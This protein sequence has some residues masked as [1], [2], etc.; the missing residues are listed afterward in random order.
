[1]PK[2][3]IRWF[4]FFAM[5]VACTIQFF[6]DVEEKQDLL[7]VDGM[8]TDQN[9]TYRIRLSRTTP[10]G[11]T[12]TRRPVK[13][14]TVTIKDENGTIAT[15]KEFPVGT[16]YTDST[17]FRGHVGGRYALNIKL[18]N[19]YYETDYI[20]MKPVPP[21]DSL[22]YEKVVITASKDSNDI[23]EGCKIYLNSYDPENKCLY[24]RWDYLE[25]WE[26]RIPY[27]TENQICWI[28]E[29]SGHILIKNTSVFD[30]AKVTKYLVNFVTNKTDR[31]KVKYS[32]LV[33]QY[34]LDQAEYDFW[35][36]VEGIS[37]NV[38]NL[39]DVTPSSVPGNVRC[40]TKPDEQVLGYFSVSAVTQKRLFVE[41]TFL[42]LPT[43]YSYCVTDT[44]YGPLPAEGQNVT[45]W[46]LDK[47]EDEVPPVYIITTYRECADCRT[48]GTKIKPPYWDDNDE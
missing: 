47:N 11:T 2:N 33:N 30:Q 43:F 42:G 3:I 32:I 24:F 36:K 27:P 39:Y 46:V 12:L 7:V 23:D 9:S 20:E 35:E 37:Q 40:I 1:M 16:Y 17:V 41:D 44:I 18:N 10:I 21:I 25:T 29:L 28:N 48:E 5:F 19:L 14:A 38:G 34:S 4:L 31:L 13:G 8:I 15:T 22:Y 6:P 45:W 26:Y